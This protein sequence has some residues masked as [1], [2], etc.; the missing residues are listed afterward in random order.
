MRSTP[1]LRLAG[2]LAAMV[3]ALVVTTAAGAV[4]GGYVVKPL[5]S[6]NGVPGTITDPHLVN[7]WGLTAGPTTPWWVA[8][9]GANV[10]TLYQGTGAIVPLVVDV[11][12][13]PDRHRFQQHDRLQALERQPGPLPLLQRGG[14]D[15]GLERRDEGRDDRRPVAGRRRVQGA[16]D[17]GD[18]RRAEAL[19]DRLREPSRR[20]VRRRRASP[21][22]VASS[23]TT[24]SCRTATRRS[25]SR[26]SGRASTS[27]TRRRSPGATTRR[28]GRASAS[29]T[30]TTP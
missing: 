24:T 18:E 27:R 30:R 20:R 6:D 25:A 10:S 15:L 21:A 12:E 4:S 13:A 5:V 2:V 26:R 11:G 22:R 9:N 7:A 19:R 28:T 3:T 17:C 23:S 8:D 14:R 16:R 1:L 29:S